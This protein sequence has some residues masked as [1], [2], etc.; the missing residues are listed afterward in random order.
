MAKEFVP[1][2]PNPDLRGLIQKII[3]TDNKTPITFNVYNH[4]KEGTTEPY[5]LLFAIST[6]I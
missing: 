2:D 5:Q 3:V 4:Q 1:I 6:Y